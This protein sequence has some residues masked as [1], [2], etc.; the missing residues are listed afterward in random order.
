MQTEKKPR[1]ISTVNKV[2]MV[3]MC[4]LLVV[5]AAISVLERI[6]YYL[7]RTEISL[8][9]LLL[10][11]FSLL[12]WGCIALFRKMKNKWAKIIGG[13]AIMMI[14]MLVVN[15]GLTY[16]AQFAQLTMPS[17]YSTITNEA[18]RK[19]VVM[20]MIDSGF[21]EGDDAV[22]AANARMNERRDYLEANGLIGEDVEEG[23]Y[24][25]ASFGY[26]YHAYPVKAGI[27]FHKKADV[28]GA[29]YRGYE[30]EAKLLYEWVDDDTLRLYLENPEVA[31]S[32]EVLLHY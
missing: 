22:Q 16:A 15:F 8:L 20:Q 12:A 28:E 7:I 4:V 14:L 32:G 23:D 17:K 9:G 6:G 10:I 26:V 30:S 24:P 29:V 27:F 31:D 3:Y 1:Q 19:A 11:P 18:G 25:L 5:M 21:G 13:F 2:I